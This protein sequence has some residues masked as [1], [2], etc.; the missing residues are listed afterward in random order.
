MTEHLFGSADAAKSC[1]CMECR[2]RQAITQ[3]AESP[4]D[5]DEALG[6]LG[7]I[8][9]ELLA[10]IPT[11]RAKIWARLTLEARR[12]WKSELRVKIQ[13]PEGHG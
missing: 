12:R 3:G 7:N 4:T 11:P 10:H 5:I 2:I 6:A 9:G 13:H 8:A 1:G